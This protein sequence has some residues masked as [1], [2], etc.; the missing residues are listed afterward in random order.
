VACTIDGCDET[1]DACTHVPNDQVCDNGQFC[2]G[3]EICDPGLGCQGGTAPCVGGSCNE[4][5]DRC[6]NCSSNPQCDDGQ[7][8]NGAETCV[9]GTC[10]TG[11]PVNCDDANACTADSCDE[12]NDVC[13]HTDTCNP[14]GAIV[15]EE[16][17]GG[18]SVEQ[19]TVATAQSLAGAAGQLYL[20]AITFKTNTVVTSVNGLGLTWTRVA[21]QCA[22]RAQTGI[23]IWA[24]Q[25]AP[26]GGGIVTA[27]LQAAVS[28]AVIAVTRYS[29]VRATAPIGMVES[30]NS[31]GV[32]GACL[33]GIDSA[34]YSYSLPS[35]TAG[36]VVHSTASMR[37]RTH[38]PGTGY[39]EIFEL[40]SGTSGGTSAS[41]ALSQKTAGA[42]GAIV[43]D[44]T[45]NGTVDWAAMALEIRP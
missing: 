33:N 43:V 7:F 22:G 9:S 11:T 39:Q 8:C 20:A 25:G 44:G 30:A 27:N 40:A 34:S 1:G 10:Q 45:F 21:A 28:G 13:Q 42:T 38:T 37:S 26:S 31:N 12:T 6:D 2:D 3:A 36:S 5:S 18:I 32:D 29:G 19:N 24:A 23:E 16:V 41:V 4:G 15:A 17:R 14:S 35:V